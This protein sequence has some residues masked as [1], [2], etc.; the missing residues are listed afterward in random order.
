MSMQT[1]MLATLIVLVGAAQNGLNVQSL[2]DLS[3]RP[4]V[5]G[6]NKALWALCIL[7]I[8]IVGALLYNWMG[9]TSFV[10]RPT[11]QDGP[12]A[13][14]TPSPGSNITSIERARAARRGGASGPQ[15]QPAPRQPGTS[16]GRSRTGS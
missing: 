2:R 3:Q 16:S 4:R 8:P 7:C 13:D 14:H 9:P 11:M 6:D 10:G 15:P 1:A 5:R 12:V